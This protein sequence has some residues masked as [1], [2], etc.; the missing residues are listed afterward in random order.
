MLSTE[1]RLLSR[2]TLTARVPACSRRSCCLA[3]TASDR[4]TKKKN[5]Q[6]KAAAAAADLAELEA[7]NTEATDCACTSVLS[8]SRSVR[9]ARVLLSL[10]VSGQRLLMRGHRCRNFSKGS[11]LDVVEK[12]STAQRGKPR[13]ASIPSLSIGAIFG[14]GKNTKP[15]R[16]ENNL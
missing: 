3:V 5:N 16:R 11:H 8:S 15:K 1:R 13:A 10:S 9:R 14:P 2:F 12:L 7:A 6:K 4:A